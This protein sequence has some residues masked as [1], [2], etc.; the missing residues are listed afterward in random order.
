MIF[1]NVKDILKH[2]NNLSFLEMVKLSG[3]DA[4]TTVESISTDKSIV[5]FGKLNNEIEDLKDNSIGLSRMG[6]LS[7]YVSFPAF[8]EKDASVKIVKQPRNGADVPAEITF[9]SGHGHQSNY[10]FMSKEIVD[11]QIKMPVFKGANYDLEYEPTQKNLQDL[12]YFSGILSSYESTF[13]TV[14]KDSKLYFSIGSSSS[15]RA[16]VPIADN[17]TCKISTN[18]K[19]PLSSILSILKLSGTEKCTMFISNQ[20]LL[21]I[22]LVSGLGTYTYYIPAKA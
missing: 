14:C 19:W 15:D 18:W 7:G 4:G 17:V 6:I 9:D 21:K 10:R 1:D 20:G 8:S 22:E 11:E 12:T 16:L 2:T 3:T 5:M 13:S